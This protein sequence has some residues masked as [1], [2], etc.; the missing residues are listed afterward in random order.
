MTN[1]T[2]LI[3]VF[4]AIALLWLTSSRARKQQQRVTRFQDSL[5]AGQEVMT[6]SG[7]FGVVVGVEDDIVILETSPGT[8]TRWLKRAIVKLVEPPVDDE[9]DENDEDET[10]P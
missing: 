1:P 4:G 8:T 10:T 9:D 3:F 5:V 2:F 6:G 7:L